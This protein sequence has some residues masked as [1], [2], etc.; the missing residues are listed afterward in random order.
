MKALPSASGRIDAQVLSYQSHEDDKNELQEEFCKVDFEDP[1]S[2]I[3]Y[4]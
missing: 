4:I 1:R 3:T 2:C